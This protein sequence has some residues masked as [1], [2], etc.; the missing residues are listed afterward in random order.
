VLDCLRPAGR[1][2]LEVRPSYD[3]GLSDDLDK[4]GR[5]VALDG[6]Q[7]ALDHLAFTNAAYEARRRAGMHCTS[8]GEPRDSGTR[9]AGANR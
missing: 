4:A 5:A 6:A 1:P 9:R 2:Y 3:A 8:K 7:R